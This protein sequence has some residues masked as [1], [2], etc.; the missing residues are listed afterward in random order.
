MTPFRN[1]FIECSP[2]NLY[3]FRS[4]GWMTITSQADS[5][6][7]IAYKKVGDGHP[8]RLWRCITEIEGPPKDVL[9]YII[10]QRASWDPYLLQSQTIKKFDEC[11]E[12]FQYAI[13]GQQCT[14]FCVLR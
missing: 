8:L 4:R 13:D 6:V 7:E 3:H 9:D 12:I 10:R 2:R 11:T 14:D 5:N 1:L